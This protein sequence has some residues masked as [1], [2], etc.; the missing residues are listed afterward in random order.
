MPDLTHCPFCGADFVVR[1]QGSG[2][3]TWQCG[4]FKRTDEEPKQAM[5]CMR[6]ELAAVKAALADARQRAIDMEAA[7]AKH[8]LQSHLLKEAFEQMK[9]DRHG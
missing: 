4:S 8:Q 6:R 2:F 5:A 3:A 1:D 9:G 7:A